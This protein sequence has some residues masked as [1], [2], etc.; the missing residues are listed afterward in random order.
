LLSD[1]ISEWRGVHLCIVAI[2]MNHDAAITITLREQRSEERCL[3][4]RECSTF[5]VAYFP[6]IRILRACDRCISGMTKLTMTGP[7][8]NE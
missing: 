7:D 8:G 5:A 4:T 6:K 1:L 3:R 2:F